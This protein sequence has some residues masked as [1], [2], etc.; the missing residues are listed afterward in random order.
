MV[1]LGFHSSTLLSRLLFSSNMGK[2][3]DLSAAE[4]CEMGEC[5]GQDMKTLGI[6]QKLKRGNHTFKRLVGDSEHTRV[7]A[8]KDTTRKVSAR[9][10]HWI[11]TAAA[12]MPLQGSKQVFEAAGAF[13]VMPTSR[14]R[15]LH[16]LAV[17][18]SMQPPLT[19]AHNQ[20]C[21]SGPRNSWRL[22]F[23]Q[24]CSLLSA[25]QPWMVPMDGVG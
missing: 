17:M 1:V 6:S 2:K 13:G 9:Q 5:L 19:N 25:V 4:K 12:T 7:C 11:K 24:L 23:K 20:K 10:I 15:I 16:R 14:C 21:S 3:K 22:I 8:E 18:H